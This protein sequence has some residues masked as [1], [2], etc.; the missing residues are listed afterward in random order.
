M[1]HIAVAVLM[2]LTTVTAPAFAADSKSGEG[3]VMF[4]QKSVYKIS[5][6]DIL[7]IVT[8]KKKQIFQLMKFWSG[9]M[10]RS[11]FPF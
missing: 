5:A 6:G 1:K 4:Q 9:W 3:T 11:V 7:R 2:V 10:G 8:W